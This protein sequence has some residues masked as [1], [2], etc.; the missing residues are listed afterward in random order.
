MNPTM[1]N[2]TKQ[3]LVF[4]S[5]SKARYCTAILTGPPTGD[6]SSTLTHGTRPSNL[7]LKLAGDAVIGTGVTFMVAPF[8]TI[9]DQAI[10]Q[11]ASGTNTIFRSG[12]QSLQKMVTSPIAFVKSPAFLYVWAVYATTY[13]VANGLKTLVEHQEQ[14][15]SRKRDDSSSL[16]KAAIFLG[17]SVTNSSAS[18]L[19]DR[20]FAQMFAANA[21]TTTG[22]A[23][24][25]PVA[26]YGLWMTRD[27]IGVGS[28]FVLPDMVA[29]QLPFEDE[30]RNRDISQL[31]V[32]IATQLVAGPLHLL[33]LD[34][35]NR[36]MQDMPWKHQVLERY[37]CLVNGYGAVVGARIARI[38]PGYGFGGVLNTKLRDG[39]RD[40]L[41]E[42][43][44]ANGL[45]FFGDRVLGIPDLVLMTL[46][47]LSQDRSATLTL[48]ATK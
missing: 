28:S 12:M 9:V 21:A 47:S 34:L 24:Q 18:I 17:T 39:W 37:H 6:E 45:P 25:V 38:I 27:L 8:L 10:T 14:K 15:S 13:S 31:C 3:P 35:F 46:H 19:K 44:T 41:V 20:A 23:R 40:Y 22:L 16:G 30:Q 11:R 4:S 42:R 26:S 48:V 2:P 36:P 1:E 5:E 33:G 32:P 29:Q 7:G 43:D